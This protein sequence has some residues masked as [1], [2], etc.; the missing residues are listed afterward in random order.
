MARWFCE[1]GKTEAA[2]GSAGRKTRRA[3]LLV[4]KAYP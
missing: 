3:G 2:Q 4:A 1:K